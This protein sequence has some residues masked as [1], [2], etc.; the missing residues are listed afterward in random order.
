MNQT[1]A[2]EWL[3]AAYSD[4]VVLE[5][6]KDDDFITNITSLHA[7]Q[8]KKFISTFEA[9]SL[10]LSLCGTEVPPPK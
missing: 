3:K 4:I 2:L 10:V 7:Q 6:I 9:F 1:L 5:K 8:A